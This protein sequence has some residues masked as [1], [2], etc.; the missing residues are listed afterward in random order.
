MPGAKKSCRRHPLPALFLVLLFTSDPRVEGNSAAAASRGRSRSR[1]HL[2]PPAGDRRTALLELL[3]RV[4]RDSSSSSS[5][6]LHRHSA[7]LHPVVGAERVFARRY[8][9]G[10][11]SRSTSA[12]A[13]GTRGASSSR[14]RVAAVQAAPRHFASSR[15]SEAVP[16]DSD[17]KDK[18]IQHFTE[19]FSK[20]PALRDKIIQLFTGPVTVSSECSTLFYRLYHNTRDCSTPAYIPAKTELWFA[21]KV[22]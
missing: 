17:I 11:L 21:G 3:L 1:E 16:R 18:F 9:T 13:Q 19:L 7:P 5:N 14:E 12:G 2:D 15:H 4:L 10:A 6:S 8:T 20:D 22:P